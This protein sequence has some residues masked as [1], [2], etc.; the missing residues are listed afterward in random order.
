MNPR[1]VILF[2]NISQQYCKHLISIKFQKLIDLSFFFFSLS[3]SLLDSFRL[4][5]STRMIT[6]RFERNLKKNDNKKE[7]RMKREIDSAK[8]SVTRQ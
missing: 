7:T 6:H 4:I 1:L 3:S 5:F 8:R 2:N